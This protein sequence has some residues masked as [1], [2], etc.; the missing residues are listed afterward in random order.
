MLV[1]ILNPERFY[2]SQYSTIIIFN[3][4]PVK[5]NDLSFFCFSD[6]K[7]AIDAVL[8]TFKLFNTLL[9]LPCFNFIVTRPVCWCIFMYFGYIQMNS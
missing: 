8:E 4:E 6:L 9:D 7:E 2:V 1:F 5:T 3:I